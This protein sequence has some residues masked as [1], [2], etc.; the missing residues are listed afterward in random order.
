ME[1]AK[2]A[3]GGKYPHVY[4]PCSHTHLVASVASDEVSYPP[5][6]STPCCCHCPMVTT[7][8]VLAH[9]ADFRLCAQAVSPIRPR[10]LVTNG[11]IAGKPAKATAQHVRAAGLGRETVQ[12]ALRHMNPRAREGR[13]FGTGRVLD[14]AQ[15][16]KGLTGMNSASRQGGTRHRGLH[17][18]YC[19]SVPA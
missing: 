4:M 3:S 16:G 19:G 2:Y 18:L 14:N 15:S 1:P 6:C 9:A 13:A 7:S 8:A 12:C 10:P 11:T 17:E 5:P